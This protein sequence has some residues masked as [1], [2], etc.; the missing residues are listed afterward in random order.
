ME[1]LGKMAGV[2]FDFGRDA[3]IGLP[4]AIFCERKPL[5]T[6]SELF[7][8]FKEGDPPILFTRLSSEIW[9]LLPA[10][11]KN[12]Y[13]YDALSRTAFAATMPPK[14]YGKVAIV[15]AGTADAPV[16][17][18]A[19]RTLHYLGITYT[20]FEDCGVTGLWRLLQN[21]EN[22]NSH[23]VIIVVAG[24]EGA[25]PSV[26]G[27][28][29]ALPIFAVPTSVGYG[30][31][32]DGKTALAGMLASCAPGIACLNIDNGY[33]AACAAARVINMLRTSIN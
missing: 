13:N 24:M 14:I 4:E 9:D 16:T 22:I 21:L 3:R 19:A 28:L 1:N 18:E 11:I 33:G 2:L 26:L 23:N 5:K 29:S 7:R 30:V 8:R 32:I 15:S 27:G 20:L 6:L 17:H 25:L 31:S 12:K 10:A